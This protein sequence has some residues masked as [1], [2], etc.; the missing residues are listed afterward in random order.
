[1]ARA[2][3]RSG[4]GAAKKRPRLTEARH[5]GINTNTVA[6]LILKERTQLAEGRFVEI[7]IWSLPQPLPGSL[8]AFKYRL[9]FV[10]DERCVIRYDNETGK[11]DH[12]H[13]F[14]R[15]TPYAYSTLDRLLEDFERDVGQWRPE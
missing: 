2:C 12:R 4:R 9:A 7:V 1:M 8:H 5:V 10:V 13:I 15:E 6:R 14:E 11:G 3:Y